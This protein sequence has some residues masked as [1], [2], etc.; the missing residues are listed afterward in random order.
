MIDMLLKNTFKSHKAFNI[1]DIGPGFND[2]SRTVAKLTEAKSIVY[3]D[4]NDDVLNWQK[5]SNDKIGIKT[6]CIKNLIEPDSI[7]TLPVFDII[8]CQ[9]IL[10]H[11]NDPSELL[12]VLSTK[13]NKNGL[14]VITVPTKISESWLGIINR[15]YMANQQHG[16]LHK[17]NVYDIKDMI[18]K[19]GLNLLSLTSTQPH[20]FLFHSWIYGARVKVDGATGLIYC[21]DFRMTVGRFLFTNSLRIFKHTGYKF[22]GKV[23]PR[24]YYIVATRN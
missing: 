6:L 5:N 19:S 13:L 22:W 12:S 2:F 18:N 23:F 20:Y 1:L 7:K 15:N 3:I 16:H 11:L 14:I 21:D 10:E 8:L 17:F 24:N 4:C 9:E